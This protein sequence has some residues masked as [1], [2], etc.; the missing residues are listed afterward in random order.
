MLATRFFKTALIFLIVAMFLGMYMGPAGDFRLKH[1]HVHLNLLGWATMALVGL[2]YSVRPE[3]EQG[4]LPRVHYWLHTIGLTIFMGGFAY[5]V[6]SGKFRGIP[7]AGGATM[8][9]IGML[10]FAFH[11]FRNMK[12]LAGAAK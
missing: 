5:G 6:L 2:L 8:V 7:V 12:P 3:L 11:V 10:M 1:V 4:R 9:L